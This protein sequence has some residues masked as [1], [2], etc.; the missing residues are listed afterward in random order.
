LDGRSLI[1]DGHTHFW[2]A[3]PEN[4]TNTARASSPAFTV[5]NVEVGATVNVS[6]HAFGWYCLFV[7]LT[8][9]PAGIY[10]F[11]NADG[12][13]ASIYL[14]ID[15]FAWAVLW[16]LFFVLL[17]LGRPIARLTGGGAGVLTRPCRDRGQPSAGEVGPDPSLTL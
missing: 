14:G 7:A 5:T 17:A 2:D 12:N 1:A 9:I 8:A 3:R 16:F 15:W 10:S 11:A 4:A 6:G 13:D